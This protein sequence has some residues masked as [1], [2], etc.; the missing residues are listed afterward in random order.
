MGINPRNLSIRPQPGLAQNV[1]GLSLFLVFGLYGE[2]LYWKTE[3]WRMTRFRDKSAMFG[4]ELGPND[5]PSWGPPGPYP[6]VSKK[7][8]TFPLDD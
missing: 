2:K 5:P 8:K 7:P 6:Y 1:I 4:K 3:S